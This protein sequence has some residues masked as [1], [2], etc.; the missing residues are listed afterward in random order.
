[1]PY[2]AS[3]GTVVGASTVTVAVNEPSSDSGTHCCRTV[4]R[5]SNGASGT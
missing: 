5:M 1:M 4:R 3:A 2:T